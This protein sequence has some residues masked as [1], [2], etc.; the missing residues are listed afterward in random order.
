MVR[1]FLWRLQ[2]EGGEDRPKVVIRRLILMRV[3]SE[4]LISYFFDKL[5]PIKFHILLSLKY[6]QREYMII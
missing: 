3:L 4:V 5:L 1:I 6:M 2:Q